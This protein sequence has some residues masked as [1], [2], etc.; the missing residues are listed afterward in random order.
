MRTQ[1]GFTRRHHQLDNRFVGFFWKF[2]RIVHPSVFSKFAGLEKDLAKASLRMAFRVYVG[3]MMFTSL[4]AGVGVFAVSYLL[5]ILAN[6]QVLNP[7][8]FPALLGMLIG[9]LSMGIFFLYPSFAARSRAGKI[10]A[11]L[12]T[13]ANF[14]SV[15]ASSGM[16]T[17]SI[18]R[19]LAR[20]GDEFG[21]SKEV[22][23]II[24]DIQ[25]LGLDLHIALKKA[26]DRSPSRGFA[27]LLDGIVTT[28][29]M[30]GDL[31]VYLREEAEKYKRERMLAVKHFIDNLGIIAEAYI[32]FMV[33]G[34]LMLI[35]MLSVM[36]FIGGGITIGSLDPMDLLNLLT[37]LFLP[38][39]VG[40]M[41]LLV[42]ATNP[43]R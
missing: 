33:A 16:P 3:L 10:E 41:I 12:P 18:F 34:P 28:I 29:H 2:S 24:R 21:I 22:E 27:K 5:F 26:A 38:A 15:L 35:I 43:Q 40:M 13:I 14:M 32:A 8:L 30:G 9:A 42:D 7:L 17:E 20:V 23:S 37:F 6:F 11:N 1:N 25:L 31:T 4:V 39:G 36:S 19:S